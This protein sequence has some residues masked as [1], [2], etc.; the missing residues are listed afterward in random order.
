[1]L[2]QTV[3]E[4]LTNR[5]EEYDVLML[6]KRFEF[7]TKHVAKLDKI[8]PECFKSIF[9]SKSKKFN[10]FMLTEILLESSYDE[11]KQLKETYFAS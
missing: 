8:I 2:T 9:K 1:M 5:K 11:R 10:Y 4:A 3:I 7:M 6:H